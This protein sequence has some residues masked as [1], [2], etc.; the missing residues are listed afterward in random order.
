MIKLFLKV[1]LVRHQDAT[2]EPLW[3]AR[4]EQPER[5]VVLHQVPVDPGDV[6][7]LRWHRPAGRTPAGRAPPVGDR[8]RRLGDGQRDHPG[9][10]R[11]PCLCEGGNGGRGGV[12]WIVAFGLHVGRETPQRRKCDLWR[13]RGGVCLTPNFKLSFGHPTSTITNS[14]QSRVHHGLRTVCCPR[15]HPPVLFADQKQRGTPHPQHVLIGAR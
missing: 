15:P 3:R 10:P 14:R 4:V 11:V 7:E 9:T 6:R 8:I 1:S 12:M 5:A 13:R 2:H